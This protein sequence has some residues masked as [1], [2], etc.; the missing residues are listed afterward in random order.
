VQILW[1]LLTDFDKY[2]LTTV[3]IF[4]FRGMAYLALSAH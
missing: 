1:L 3:G 2:Y 4:H